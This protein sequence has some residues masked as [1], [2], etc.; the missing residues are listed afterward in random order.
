MARQLLKTP[1]VPNYWGVRN[2]I[3]AGF[4]LFW[5]F[6]F[7]PEVKINKSFCVNWLKFNLLSMR[8][9]IIAFLVLIRFTSFAQDAEA[10]Y[11][12]VSPS[13]VTIETDK[14]IGSGFFIDKNIVVTNFHVID[15]AKFANCFISNSEIRYKISGIVAVD[16]ENDLALLSVPETNAPPIKIRQFHLVRKFM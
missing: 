2:I 10:I 9:T 11:K 6:D 15:G 13:T 5:E 3:V 4:W 12:T 1:A 14:K 8:N 7:S 16:R